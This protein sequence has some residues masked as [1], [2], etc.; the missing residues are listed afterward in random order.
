MFK[1]DPALCTV[2]NWAWDIV[3]VDNLGGGGQKVVLDYG[4]KPYSLRLQSYCL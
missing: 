3:L 1:P 2:V 4:N